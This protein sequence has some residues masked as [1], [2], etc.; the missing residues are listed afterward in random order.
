MSEVTLRDILTLLTDQMK[1]VK[2][3]QETLASNQE[4]LV[5]ATNHKI[6]VLKKQGMTAFAALG[7]IFAPVIVFNWSILVERT[8]DFFF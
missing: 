1:E 4:Q 5:E 8:K 6:D 3:K 7:V 2:E